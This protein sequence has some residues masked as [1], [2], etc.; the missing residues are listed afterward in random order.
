MRFVPWWRPWRP[1]QM[2]LWL[3]DNDP[4][5]RRRSHRFRRAVYRRVA[6]WRLLA[7]CER[8]RFVLARIWLIFLS[9]AAGALT[10]LYALDSLGY[11]TVDLSGN[12]AEHVVSLARRPFPWIVLSAVVGWLGSLSF[13]ARHWY[14][15]GHRAPL[16]ERL[17]RG[18]L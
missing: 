1:N 5:D 15:H 7:L 2:S 18:G 8:L 9:T 17:V 10:M 13:A 4:S 6:P 11:L 14:D 12:V 16:L 3:L